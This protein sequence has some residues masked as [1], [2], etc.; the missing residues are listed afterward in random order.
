MNRQIVIHPDYSGLRDFITRLPDI[1]LHEGEY[2]HDGRNKI[3]IFDVCGL[4]VNVKR[5]RIPIFFNRF[6][7]LYLRKTKAE[8][9]YEYALR[10]QKMGIHTPAPIAYIIEKKGMLLGYSYFIS[11]QEDY[12]RRFYEFGD[13]ELTEEH[14]MIWKEFGRYTARLHQQ[15][16]CHQ[17]YSPGNILFD[18]K[19]GKPEFCIV[20]INRMY[21]GTVSFKKGCANFARLWGKPE[22]FRIIATA[23]AGERGWDVDK[24]CQEVLQA[25]KKHWQK[26][27]RKREVEFP[28]E[29]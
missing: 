4:K 24:T 29:F 28:L 27:A 23:Y 16:V 26:V 10:L 22:M 1:F 5:Y 11:I 18:L 12:S 19:N 8:R 2:L 6:I 21:F 7:Y 3:K 15:N 13:A 9:A 20:D 14:A 25:R 17:D